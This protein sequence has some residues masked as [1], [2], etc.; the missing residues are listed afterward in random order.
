MSFNLKEATKNISTIS[1]EGIKQEVSIESVSRHLGISGLKQSGERLQGECPSGHTSKKGM[2]FNINLE[3]NYYNCFH[4]GQG[5][6]VISLVEFVKEISFRE[7]MNWLIAEFNIDINE[8]TD[9]PEAQEKSQ[10]T[11]EEIEKEKEFFTRAS[12]YELVFEHGRRL[13][14]EPVG[15]EAL[16]YLTGDRCY[17]HEEIKASEWLYLPKSST[18]KDYLNDLQ[19]DAKEAIAKLNLN[20]YYGDNF[21]LAFP[22]RNRQGLIT[23]FVKRALTPEGIEVKTRDGQ[24]HS[25]IRWDSSKGLSKGDLFNLCNCKDFDTLIILEGYPDAMM[26]PAMDL[27]NVVAVGQGL[28]SKKHLEGLVDFGVKSVILAFDND[29]VGI[30]NTMSAI[31]MLLSQTDINVFVLDPEKMDDHKDPDEFVK[32]NGINKFKNLVDNAEAVG[33]WM[34]KQI[35]N[36]LE[37]ENDLNKQKALDKLLDYHLTLKDSLV[38]NDFITTASDLL[39]IP[40]D[41]LEEK[42]VS[43]KEKREREKVVAGYNDLIDSINSL[44]SVGKLEKAAQLIEKKSLDL[45]NQL[46]KTKIE[47]ALSLDEHLKNK[48]EIESQRDGSLLGFRLNKFSKLEKNIDGLQTG[49][50]IIG[51]ETNVGKTA[52]LTNLFLDVLESNPETIGMYFSLDDSKDVIINRLLGIIS[53]LELNQVQRKQDNPTDQQILKN[54]YDKLITFARSRRIHIKDLSEVTHINHL[55]VVIREFANENLFVGIDGLFN[56]EVD[57]NGGGIREENV[58]R[59]EKLKTL[60][61]TY[62][63]PIICTGE[64]RKKTKDEGKNKRPSVSDIMETGKFGYNANVVWLLS[65]ES[66]D[67]TKI[68]FN[69][70]NLKLDYAKNK[71]SHFKGYQD[72]IFRKNK[73]IVEENPNVNN[74]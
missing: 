14:F 47:P 5:G 59:A 49:L 10:K 32:A 56:L 69:K 37:I 15:S 4:C 67:A 71:L 64:L 50:Y 42:T 65:P 3:K 29:G 1:A 6:D 41:I 25:G 35:V 61:D 36:G 74:W 57:R 9:L 39:S 62:N 2:C 51:A 48:Y 52:F 73:G 45:K 26:L 17:A 60:V 31:D 70:D 22:Y 34:C 13:L 8:C 16:N 30:E 63:I 53:N 24:M 21:R 28:L 7:A 33:K 68:N 54:A 11:P 43:F 72:I 18:V 27:K 55:E 58:E 20:G 23:G 12:L 44:V 46:Y 19:P 40:V 38:I 66:F